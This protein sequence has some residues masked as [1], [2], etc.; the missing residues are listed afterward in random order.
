[1]ANPLN[2]PLVSLLG[3]SLPAIEWIAPALTRDAEIIRGDAG[4]DSGLPLMV[5]FKQLLVGPSIGTVMRDKNRQIA[6]QPHIPLVGI[7]LEC[8]PLSVKLK[9]QEFLEV[10]VEF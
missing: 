8:P 7:F 3:M 10:D 9:L 2:P 5:Q 1:M 6:H 4:H